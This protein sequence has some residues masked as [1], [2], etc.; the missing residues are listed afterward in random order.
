MWSVN[1]NDRLAGA[2]SARSISVWSVVP[3]ELPSLRDVLVRRCPSECRASELIRAPQATHLRIPRGYWQALSTIPL[4]S[5]RH[6]AC[7][8]GQLRLSVEGE[9]VRV[10]I[11][12]CLACQR[13]TGSVF[14]VQ[15]RFDAEQVTIEG[16]SRQYIRVSDKGDKRAS[17]TTGLADYADT[18]AMRRRTASNF[19]FCPDCG[20]TVFYTVEASPGN[21][22]VPVG[23]FA[24]P[25]F[26][27]PTVS[28]WEERRHSWLRLPDDIEHVS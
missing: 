26:P 24:D 6:A 7:S 22:A 27:A 11:C 5:T 17:D 10:S 12:H 13:R 21:V 19:H 15:A 16:A 18:R 4:V 14:G 3:A 25:S 28:V 23:A 2:V 20:A 8:C 9:P 1:E